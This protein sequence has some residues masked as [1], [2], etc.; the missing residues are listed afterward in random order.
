MKRI[1]CT[2]L[3]VIMALGVCGMNFSFAEEASDEKLALVYQD[4]LY[5]E[6]TFDEAVENNI[7]NLFSGFENGIHP[8]ENV[9]VDGMIF[10][11]GTVTIPNEPSQSERKYNEVVLL[12]SKPESGEYYFVRIFRVNYTSETSIEEYFENIGF[13]TVMLPESAP[14]DSMLPVGEELVFE[15]KIFHEC[16]PDISVL[17][18]TGLYW[19]FCMLLE[20]GT[21]ISSLPF[22]NGFLTYD[23][24]DVNN[25]VAFRWYYDENSV[26]IT[27]TTDDL[28][29]SFPIAVILQ[30]GDTIESS[31][32]EDTFPAVCIPNIDQHDDETF[33]FLF[34]SLKGNYFIR[35]AVDVCTY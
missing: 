23:P 8:V 14:E 24:T 10:P 30:N 2:I 12:L 7:I 19:D 22:M 16:K 34:D 15:G 32:I 4:K 28:M 11:D 26:D 18:S 29:Y 25:I 31:W 27:L 13:E 6:M 35:I 20:D 3:A 17:S 9:L 5:V 1:F 21:I 33:L